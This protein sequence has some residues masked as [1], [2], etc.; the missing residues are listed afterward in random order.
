MTILSNKADEI[1]ATAPSGEYEK[2]KYIYEYIVNTTDYDLNAPD[3]Q[4]PYSALINGASVCG[5]YAGAFQYLCDKAGIYCGSVSGE[6][7]GRG[8]HA[9]NFVRLND[10]FY[11]IDVTWGDPV[12]VDGS[13]RTD[14]LNYDYLC[15]DDSEILPG[16]ILPNDSAYSQHKSYMDFNYPRCADNSLNY[17][18]KAGCYFESY[19]RQEIYEYIITQVAT[20]G[21]S[22]ITLKF[23]N[24]ADYQQA[25]AEIM[26]VEYLQQLANDLSERYGIK[27]SHRTGTVGY[28]SN[29]LE[30]SFT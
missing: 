8:L 22:K 18:R 11:W 27:I 23:A 13:A 12:F 6:I 9:W 30:M 14:N 19:D 1:L 21:S 29:R 20:H 10:Q 5:G 3:N 15:V 7:R 25:Y 16:R 17:Y 28:T 26:T 24:A 2:I 4:S